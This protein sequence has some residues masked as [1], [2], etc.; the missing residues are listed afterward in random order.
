MARGDFPCRRCKAALQSIVVPK[1]GVS[2]RIIRP[3]IA[4]ITF[5]FWEPLCLRRGGGYG[6]AMRIAGKTRLIWAASEC[7]DET[8]GA[9]RA[10]H[11]ELET[12]TWRSFKDVSAAYPNSTFQTQRL[13]VPIDGQHC[14]VVAKKREMRGIDA[15][16]HLSPQCR[17]S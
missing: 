12:V 10:F 14:V 1:L 4:I 11:A 6:M 13:V 17:P 3:L 15:T 7:C 5:P 8:A 16:W 2:Q 9:Y